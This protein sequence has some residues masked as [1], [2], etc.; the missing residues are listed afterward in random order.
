MSTTETAADRIARL[1]DQHRALCEARAAGT[2][3]QAVVDE[4][5]LRDPDFMWDRAA[6]DSA[7]AASTGIEVDVLGDD[8]GSEPPSLTLLRADLVADRALMLVFLEQSPQA[9]STAL[10][11]HIQAFAMTPVAPLS[12]NDETRVSLWFLVRA[13][14]LLA[15]RGLS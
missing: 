13:R 15:A 6:A 12:T 5:E 10:R 11:D 14:E 8:R 7:L 2:L 9:F 1:D 4:V 3:P